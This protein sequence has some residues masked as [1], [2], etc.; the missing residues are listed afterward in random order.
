[1]N[2]ESN[3]EAKVFD[4]QKGYLNLPFD[5]GQFKNFIKGLLGTPQ[6]ITKRMKG[7]FEIHL[8]DLQNFHNL[9]N[10][11]VTQQNKGTLVQLK[12][13]VYYSD[14]SSVLLSSYDELVSYREV[15]PIISEAVRMTWVYLIQFEDKDVP[16]K[17]EIELMI[18]ST[19]QRNVVADDD[20]SII[21]PLSGQIRMAI[22]HTAR[23]WGADIES[24]LTN[25]I[26]SILIKPNKL[27]EFLQKNSSNIGL[28]TGILFFICSL[29]TVFNWT[30]NFNHNEVAEAS[31]IIESAKNL[32][33]KVDTILQYLA[34]NSHNQ[35][36]QKINIFISIS[37]FLAIFLGFWVSS[38]ANNKTRSYL[39]LTAEAKSN[40]ER[41]RKKSRNKIV[42][43][44]VSIGMSIITKVLASFAFQ[45]CNSL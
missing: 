23:S 8:S 44:F 28:F 14:E 30:S 7:N 18:I 1:M 16:E 29:I 10:Q 20:I 4:F 34:N 25:Q 2:Q 42:L 37:L 21:F 41:L 31:K 11:R 22:K 15:K 13:Q 35:F 36:S 33:F 19:V 43:F 17:Q 3:S 27:K 45:W 40:M 9:I 12:T 32:D 38:L 24:L 5:Q 39:V 26:N 6:T